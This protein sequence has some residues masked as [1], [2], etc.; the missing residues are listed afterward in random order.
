VPKLIV[1]LTEEITIFGAKKPRKVAGKIDTGASQSSIDTDL[2]T[3]MNLGPII[4]AKVIR[5]SH[6]TTLRAV[7]RAEI[8]FGRKRIRAKFNIADRRH[9]RYK[10]LLG[11]NILKR[12]GV[13]VDPSRK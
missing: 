9:M 10:M 5:S 6:G 7:V 8:K 1:G 4:S 3:K 12:L 2:A 11:V 13:L